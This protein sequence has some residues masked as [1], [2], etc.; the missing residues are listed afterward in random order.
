MLHDGRC[1]MKAA[2][3]GRGSALERYAVAAERFVGVRF[4]QDYLQRSTVLALSQN[5]GIVGGF[6]LVRTGPFRTL[7]QHAVPVRQQ[8]RA[9]LQ[10]CPRLVE[11]NGLFLSPQ[12][13]DAKRLVDFWNA[14]AL[15]VEHSDASHC[16]F[17]YA[18][19]DARLNQFYRSLDT[20]ELHCG[21]VTPLE[22]M[23]KRQ[24]E[25]TCVAEVAEIIR[26]L[27]SNNWLQRRIERRA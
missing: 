6:V 23:S 13:R 8:L 17:S 5:E 3:L 9:T 12:V 21:M 18:V 4:P 27:R 11:L 19:E 25:R 24:C 14:I 7:E 1:A 15:C 22:G 10:R 2:L 16:I 26:V 20:F